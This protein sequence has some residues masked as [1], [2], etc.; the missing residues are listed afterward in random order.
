MRVRDIMTLRPVTADV[1]TPVRDLA[2]QMEE[3]HCGEIPITEEN[4]LVGVVTDRDIVCRAVAKGYD[5]NST[6]A[7]EVMTRAPAKVHPEDSLGYAVRVMEDVHVRRLPVVDA[8]ATL[9]GILSMTDVC[10]YAGRLRAGDLVRKIS[11]PLH[12]SHPRGPEVFPP[13]S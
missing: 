13:Y 4:R 5:P 8:N 12:V 6:T 7:R 2:L 1:D 3:A 9:V 11:R 10:L